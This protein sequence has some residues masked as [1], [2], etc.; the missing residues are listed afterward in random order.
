MFWMIVILSLLS[1]IG[2]IRIGKIENN[3]MIGTIN[4]SLFNITRNQCIC[5]L[6]KSTDLISALNYFQ[7][8]NTCQLFYYNTSSIIIKFNSNSSFIFINRSS[9]SITTIQSNITS[10]SSLSLI[11]A[12]WPFDGN[13][14]ERN[15]NYNSFSNASFSSPGITGYG[16]ALSFNASLYQYVLTNSTINLNISF[17]SFTFEFWIYPF[18]LVTGDRGMI[19]QCQS[20]SPNKCLHMTIRNSKIR[21]SFYSNACDGTKTIVINKWYHLTFVYDLSAT[22]QMIYIDGILD[23]ISSTSAPLQI[24][25]LTYIPITIGYTSPLSPYY[26]DGLIDQLSLV[27]WV[28]NSSEILNDATLVSWYCFDNNNSTND[29]GPNEI[30]GISI[31]TIF[32]NNTLLLNQ[33]KSYFQSSGFVLL[34]MDNHSYS[35][36]IWINPIQTHNTTILFISQ[37]SSSSTKWCLSFLRF[38]SQGKIQAQSRT[39]GGLINVTG[40]YISSYTWTHI[41][42]TYSLTNGVSLYINGSLFDKSS[43][44]DYRGGNTPLTITLGSYMDNIN[45][46]CSNSSIQGGQYFGWIDEFRVYSRELTATDA[47]VASATDDQRRID[48]D[49]DIEI[50]GP[51]AS[52]IARRAAKRKQQMAVDNEKHQ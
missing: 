36:S 29:S 22:T 34:G 35:F 49:L 51:E 27:E 16:S 14:N 12:F 18:S 33:T 1:I 25:N 15:S 37:N 19:G 42:Q 23:C 6:I 39:N 2:S 26:F 5:Q 4:R 52:R 31:N 24:T 20:L 38:N 43:S 41:V 13:T 45:S 10:T 8:N 3:I 9:I 7:T 21:I 30:N 46:I 28:K 50:S 44:C 32:E 48:D 40:P 11:N 47:A 17:K